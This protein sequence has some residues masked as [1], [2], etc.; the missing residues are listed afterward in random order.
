MGRLARKFPAR[1]R[2]SPGKSFKRLFGVLRVR[3]TFLLA[4]VGVAC[5]TVNDA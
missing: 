1:Q 5:R 4:E 2:R 3:V